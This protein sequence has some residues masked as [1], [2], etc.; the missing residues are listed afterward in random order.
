MFGRARHWAGAGTVF[1]GLVVGIQAAPGY[2]PVVG[3]PPLR[4]RSP[5][6]PATNLVHLALP[7]PDLP[8]SE[9]ATPPGGAYNQTK[10]TT[11]GGTNAAPTTA[12]LVSGA[13]NNPAGPDSTPLTSQ[14]LISPQM[15]LKFFNR[16]TNAPGNEVVAPMNFAPPTPAKPPSSTATYSTDPP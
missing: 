7:P 1:A 2:L 3:P 6:Q 13:T 9:P 11:P 16:S 14:P 5:P 15:L 12:P 10:T 4:F 8:V